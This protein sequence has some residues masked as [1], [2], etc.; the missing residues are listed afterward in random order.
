MI[1]TSSLP[2]YGNAGR[3]QVPTS[4]NGFPPAKLTEPEFLHLGFAA[5]GAMVSRNRFVTPGLSPSPLGQT[6][7]SEWR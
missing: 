6:L 2:F 5:T 3:L 1:Q 4:E 7:P